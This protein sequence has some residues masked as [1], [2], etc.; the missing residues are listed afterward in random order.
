MQFIK[1]IVYIS[2]YQIKTM[3]DWF[4][5]PS[6]ASHI[7]KKNTGQDVHFYYTLSFDSVAVSIFHMK[8]PAFVIIKWINN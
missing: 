4:F 8:T 2:S 1:L 7:S 5:F 6:Y 3:M